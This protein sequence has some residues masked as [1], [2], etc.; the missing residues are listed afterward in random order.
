MLGRLNHVAIAV[1]DL[2]SATNT[3]RDI[4]GAKVGEPLDQPE[5]GVTVV[6]IELPNT[7]V[8]LITPLGE[9]SPIFNFL[10][11]NKNGGIH[12]IC[13]EV[14]NLELSMNILMKNNFIAGS[15]NISDMDEEA[16]KF[17]IIS[18]TEKAATL[19]TVMSN[20]FGFGGTNAALIFEK[21]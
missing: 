18:K 15:A 12:H 16:K 6:F 21:V 20:S 19:N 11:K 4:L 14:K 2:K 7:K 13:Y 1:T 10:N 3:Y 17:P 5:H 8:E 9:N